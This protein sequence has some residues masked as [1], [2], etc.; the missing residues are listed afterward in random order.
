VAEAET[1]LIHNSYSSV[2]LPCPEMLLWFL[3]FVN[4]VQ[5]MMKVL[6]PAPQV[7]EF[8][9]LNDVY[10]AGSHGMDIM[11]PPRRHKSGDTKYQRRAVDKKVCFSF[12]ILHRLVIRNT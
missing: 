12:N 6:Q 8:V 3:E 1:R 9:Q 11:A 2:S 4:T 10:Y 5:D 7:Y